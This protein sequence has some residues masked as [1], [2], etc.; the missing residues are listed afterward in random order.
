MVFSEQLETWLATE[1]EKTVGDLGSVFEERS[2]AVTILFLMIFPALPIP[3]GGITHVFEIIV[4]LLSLEMII[5]AKTIWLPATLRDRPLGAA[6]ID[7]ALPFMMRRIRWFEKFLRPRG[8]ALLSQRWFLR[9]VGL[10]FLLFAATAFFAPPFSGLDTF[11]A[12]AAVL[13]ALGLITDDAIAVVVGIGLG[14]VA[15]WLVVF[16]GKAVVHFVEHLF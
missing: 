2:F 15:L 16:L 5:G 1:G 11:P 7:K 8:A 6:M 12:L 9:I 13:V 10:A 3:T 14:L 4:A